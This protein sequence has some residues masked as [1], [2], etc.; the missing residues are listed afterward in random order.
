V[1]IG[2]ARAGAPLLTLAVLPKG[3]AVA[4]LSSALPYT[5]EMVALRHLSTRTYGTL[6]SAEPAVAALAGLALLGERLT[7]LQWTG[8]AS[9]MIASVGTLGGEPALQD[10]VP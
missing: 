6:M 5:L 3:V 1:P 2:L 9:V 7:L 8:I 10:Q 4:L